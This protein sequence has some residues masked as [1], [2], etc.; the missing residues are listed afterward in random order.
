MLGETG[1]EYS[2]FIRPYI[3]P[4]V[5][6]VRRTAA[7]V[8]EVFVIDVKNVFYVFLNFGHV[9]YVFNV[10]FIFQTF[11]IF[12]NTLAKFRVASRLT[13]SKLTPCHAGAWHSCVMAPANCCCDVYVAVNDCLCPT[14]ICIRNKDAASCGD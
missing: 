9:F 1:Y 4:L 6:C 7:I 13:R 10:F 12:K 5:L 8:V 11:S 14:L 2:C 3:A